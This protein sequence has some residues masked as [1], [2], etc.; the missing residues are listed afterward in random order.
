MKN[1]FFS[2]DVT[3]KLNLALKKGNELVEKASLSHQE[4][5]DV[6]RSLKMML[7]SLGPDKVEKMVKDNTLENYILDFIETKIER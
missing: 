4:K 7:A 2:E 3:E 5:V 6:A 1:E